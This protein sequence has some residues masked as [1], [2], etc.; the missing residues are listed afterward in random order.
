M[1]QDNQHVLLGGFSDEAAID[2]T[3]DQQFAAF[4]AIG[5]QWLTIRFV[6]TGSGI[7]NVMSLEPSEIDIVKQKLDAYD[8]RVSC[9]GSPIGKVKLHDIDDGTQNKFIPFDQYL[10]KDV[11]RA[12]QLANEFDA[13][14][15]R[16]FSFYHPK[17]TDVEEHI[18]QATDQLGKTTERCAEYDLVFGLEV[19]TNLVGYS[20]QIL[21]RIHEAVN[22]P[23]LKL[24]FD[25][26]NLVTQ[27]YTTEEVFQEYTAMKPGLG[28][29]HVKDYRLADTTQRGT[30]IDEEALDQYVPATLGQSG[31][32][33]ILEDV[34]SS[35]PEF[36]N[37]MQQLGVPGFFIDL[38]PHVK[39]GGQFGGFSGPDGIGVALRELI[40]LLDTANLPYQL[41]SF[42]TVKQA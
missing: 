1:S 28:W 27:G 21:K 42:D 11:R 38:E 18:N 36:N 22:H 23:N 6:D 19:E 12:C 9:I 31:Y 29:L 15:I 16:G 34:A 8:L 17:D 10:E 14:L 7:K 41:R 39:G 25:G 37:T 3:L 30:Y 20:G 5:L 26:G 13:K 4:A 2:K 32:G 33:D 24:V 35:L 40:T